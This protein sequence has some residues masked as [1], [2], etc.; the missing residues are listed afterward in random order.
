[1]VAE[2]VAARPQARAYR[3]LVREGQVVEE[4]IATRFLGA[5]PEVE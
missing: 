5:S 1:M 2:A 4:P 3:V